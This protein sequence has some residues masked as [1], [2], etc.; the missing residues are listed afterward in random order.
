[1]REFASFLEINSRTSPEMASESSG[2]SPPD[3]S[4][5]GQE[6]HSVF[7]RIADGSSGSGP[8]LPEGSKSI[9]LLLQMRKPDSNS[10][11][12]ES[13]SLSMFAIFVFCWM[14]VSEISMPVV[15][16]K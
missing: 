8:K 16:I 7:N 1:M 5:Y 13:M 9:F 14:K 15:L 10:K 11:S 2:K 6:F 4:Q 3:K 12:E